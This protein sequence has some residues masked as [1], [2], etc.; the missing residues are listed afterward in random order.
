MRDFMSTI[1]SNFENINRMILFSFLKTGNSVFDAIIPTIIISGLGYL[2]NYIYDNGIDK[3]FFKMSFDDFKSIFFTKNTIIIEGRRSSVTSA[4]SLTHTTSSVYSDRFKAMWD[5]IISNIDRNNTI[6]RIKEAHSNFQSSCNDSDEKRKNYDIFMVYQNKHFIIDDNIFVKSEIEQEESRDDKERLNT[7]TDKITINI[8]SYNYSVSY[9]KKYIDKITE[10]YL[11][12]IKENRGNKKFIYTLDKVSFKE[13]D[14]SI[15]DCWREDIFES[16]R[17]FNN[18]FFD[19]KKEILTKIDYFLNNKEWYIQKGIPYSLG[20][21]LHGP[22]GTGKTSFIKALANYTNRHII[23][24]SLKIIKTKRELEQFFFENTYNDKNEKNNISFD[25]KIIVFEDI[26][27]IGEIVLDRKKKET[28]TRS[29]KSSSKDTTN[30]NIGDVLQSIC[31]L[32]ESG[33]CKVMPA[34]NDEAITLD[35]ILNLWDGIRETPGRILIISSNHYDK[36]D[37]ALIRPGRIDITHELSN[38]SHNTI[39]EIYLHLFGNKINKNV[40]SEVKEFFYSPAEIINMYVS[41]KN[42]E[43]F[44]KRLLQNKKIK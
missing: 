15:L 6:H 11:S 25:K 38:T 18:I 22:P 30:V 23:V 26:D 32:N 16:Y 20:I 5:Y 44:M 21:G 41:Y 4:Y 35:D 40:L 8:Y 39:S 10:K 9:L 19:G 13:S 33:T 14:E 3:I 12:S 31:D 29:G 24:I 34:K 1:H 42:E 37:S 7:K 2:V 43:E 27:C 17:N 28:K 36:L